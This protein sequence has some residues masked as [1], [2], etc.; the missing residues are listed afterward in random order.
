MSNVVRRGVSS[1]VTILLLAGK[2]IY[3]NRTNYIRNIENPIQFARVINSRFWFRLLS[4]DLL[5]T[6]WGVGG[7]RQS[8][9]LW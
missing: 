9:E 3:P 4:L 8:V 1:A 6:K 5:M 2:A 7:D